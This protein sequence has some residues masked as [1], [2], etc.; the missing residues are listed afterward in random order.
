MGLECAEAKYILFWSPGARVGQEGLNVS[1][2][3]LVLYRGV[4]R[5]GSILCFSRLGVSGVLPEAS[6]QL[7][8]GAP[9]TK[10]NLAIWQCM[11]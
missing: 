1:N 2:P 10:Y 6:L 9:V 3:C 7:Q 8:S 4:S 11:M 5:S